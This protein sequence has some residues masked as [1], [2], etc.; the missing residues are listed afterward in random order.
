MSKVN[1]GG[2]AFPMQQLV[3]MGDEYPC[4][5]LVTEG[6]MSLR[7][8]FAGQLMTGWMQREDNDLFTPS[9]LAAQAYEHADAMIEARE[10]QA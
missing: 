1:D 7:D 9:M 5:Q 6:G 2:A 4:A 3:E 8:W 10:A